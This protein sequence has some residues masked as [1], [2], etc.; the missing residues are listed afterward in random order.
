[1]IKRLN[2]KKCKVVI[3]WHIL[4]LILDCVSIND[5]KKLLDNGIS[6]GDKDVYS[7]R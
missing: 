3:I 4:L 7:N 6:R 2:M 1:M 5:I